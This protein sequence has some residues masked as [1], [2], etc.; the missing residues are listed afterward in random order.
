MMPKSPL[1]FTLSESGAASNLKHAAW[2]PAVHPAVLGMGATRQPKTFLQ[3]GHSSTGH[4]VGT[5]SQILYTSVLGS[6]SNQSSQA[7]VFYHQI[8][9]WL[10]SVCS[11]I[12]LITV[13]Q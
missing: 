11:L 10:N 6:I 1:I 2:N 4:H 13:R 9:D 12:L 3:T 8:P 5:T 7:E